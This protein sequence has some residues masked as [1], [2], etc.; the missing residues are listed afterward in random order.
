MC[1]WRICTLGGGDTAH[2]H[3]EQSHKLSQGFIKGTFIMCIFC[4]VA[5]LSLF[6]LYCKHLFSDSMVM[7]LQFSREEIPSIVA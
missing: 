7:H 1:V 2:N 3:H 4:K 5:C 6:L